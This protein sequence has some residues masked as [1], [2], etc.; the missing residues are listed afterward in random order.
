M[1][2][3]VEL[4]SAPADDTAEDNTIKVCSL[5]DNVI[6]EINSYEET[7]NRIVNTA[8]S[9]QFKDFTWNELRKFVDKFGSRFEGT[10]N[11]E[12]SIDYMLQN[13]RNH[14]LE[15]VHGEPAM[16]PHWVRGSESASLILPREK[17]IALL[18]L[19]FSVGT[20]EDGIT[21]EAIVVKSFDE[22]KQ[23]AE[24]IP[25]KIVVFNQEFESYRK[26]VTYRSGGAR[27]A[28]KLGAV[29]ALIRSIT[30]VSLYTPH[31]GYMFYA[32][33][34]KKIPAACITVEDAELLY[35]LQQE[36]EE[37]KINLKMEAQLLP[38]VESRNV[39]AELAG[40]KQ[41]EKIVI[42]SG[43]IDSWDVGQ[44]AMDDG[45]GAFIS[46]SSIVLLKQLDLRP[47][48]TIRAILWTA[49]EMG[50]FGAK[51]YIKSPDAEKRNLQFVMESDIGTFKPLG[52]EVSGNDQVMCIVQRVLSL[53]KP[54]GNLKVKKGIEGDDIEDWLKM[55]VPGAS[56]WNQ[57]DKYFW[58]HHTKADT[59]LVL[60]P[61]SL[62]SGTAL[63]AAVSYVLADISID[64]P[65]EIPHK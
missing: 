16:V 33:N 27:E 9:G 53:L 37:L 58:Y 22:L 57:N 32:E 46:W 12:N 4:L 62:D 6:N 15:N 47:K 34:V 28:A 24:E 44:G 7:V 61:S 55:G 64:L 50:A 43:H 42:V 3:F 56:L 13:L 26:T 60:D 35:R 1:L 38:E 31:T 14:S 63:F 39:V 29:A 52:L 18:G 48:R 23:R 21:A 30:P 40:D 19:G 20:P 25:G 59:M 10:Q 8:T 36:G 65:Q 49:E 54:L 5:P 2:M 51:Q 17:D 11:L 45:G 41:S